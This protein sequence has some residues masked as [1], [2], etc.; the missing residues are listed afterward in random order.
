MVTFPPNGKKLLVDFFDLTIELFPFSPASY[1]F[2]PHLVNQHLLIHIDIVLD[3]DL[4]L[5]YL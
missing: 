5:L 1:V 3:L 4:L 2:M